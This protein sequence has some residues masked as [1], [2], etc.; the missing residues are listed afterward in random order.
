MIKLKELDLTGDVRKMIKKMS[1]RDIE[2]RISTCGED[3]EW[4][5]YFNEYVPIGGRYCTGN[6]SLP[7]A[8][9]KMLDHLKKYKLI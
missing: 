9:K 6:K 3:D 4:G 2:V 1:S 7:I 5:L 8:I